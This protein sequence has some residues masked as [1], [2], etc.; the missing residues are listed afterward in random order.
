MSAFPRQRQQ[1]AIP[2]ATE[3]EQD[4][5]QSIP[6]G[7]QGWWEERQG[8]G[9]GWEG[10]RVKKSRVCMSGS[11]DFLTER[12]KKKECSLKEEERVLPS[13]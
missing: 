3:D 4:A 6:V 1:L 13:G 10:R 2:Q 7:I 8:V 9:R 11:V 5:A 12:R